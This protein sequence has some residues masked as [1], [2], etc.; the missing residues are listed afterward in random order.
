LQVPALL[1]PQQTWF[2]PPHAAAHLS[3]VADSTQVRP[4]VHSVAPGQHA[5][6]LPPHAE[7]VPPPP[8]TSPV[9]ANAVP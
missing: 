4:V 6:P 2:A 8:S 5:C 7:Q 9:Q 3:P 1:L